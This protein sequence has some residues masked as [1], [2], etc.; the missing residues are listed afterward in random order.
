MGFWLINVSVM[1]ITSQPTYLHKRSRNAKQRQSGGTERV[2]E[3]AVI[4]AG[5]VR[6][7]IQCSSGIHVSDVDRTLVA[8]RIDEDVKVEGQVR[9]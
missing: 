4:H 5:H 8:C 1:E 9:G 6:V 7:T 2:N 3:L